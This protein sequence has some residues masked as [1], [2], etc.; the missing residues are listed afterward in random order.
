MQKLSSAGGGVG[1]E[2]AQRHKRKEE[3]ESGVAIRTWKMNE[4]NT[5]TNKIT[6]ESFEGRAAN[7]IKRQN[8]KRERSGARTTENRENNK[9]SGRGWGGGTLSKENS[10]AEQWQ[11]RGRHRERQRLENTV[12]HRST[13]HT[14][15]RRDPSNAIQHQQRRMTWSRNNQKKRGVDPRE[16]G[17]R[18][19]MS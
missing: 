18:E 13:T 2:D 6:S 17:A 14:H 8:A 15:T 4:T 1:I 5:R 16:T 11:M 12:A 3:E 7:H 19:E 10:V 9:R